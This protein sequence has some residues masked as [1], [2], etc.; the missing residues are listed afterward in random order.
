MLL[1]CYGDVMLM[2]RRG[3]A[4]RKNPRDSTS[5]DTAGRRVERQCHIASHHE[6]RRKRMRL[7]REKKINDDNPTQV[8]YVANT[9][10]HL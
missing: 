2:N 7:V 5:S 3:G 1:C 6:D 8:H 4:T 9:S 10:N